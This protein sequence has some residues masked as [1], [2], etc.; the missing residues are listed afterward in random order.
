MKII[1]NKG[2]LMRAKPKPQKTWRKRWNSLIDEVQKNPKIKDIELIL[3]KPLKPR[4][5]ARRHPGHYYDRIAYVH[6]KG[7]SGAGKYKHL[8]SCTWVLEP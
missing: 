8:D 2:E 1:I 6:W 3:I 7:S 4:E 5:P